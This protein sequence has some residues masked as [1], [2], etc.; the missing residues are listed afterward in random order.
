MAH[1]V[2]FKFDAGLGS[3]GIFGATG[4]VGRAPLVERA[5]SDIATLGEGGK[6]GSTS[7]DA[8]NCN[9]HKLCAIP[10]PT[11]KQSALR[12]KIRISDLGLRR[13]WGFP[14]SH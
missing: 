9:V 3:S 14:A 13:L 4:R 6:V 7:V 5:D 2:D 8:G 11:V 10:I 12:K 1:E